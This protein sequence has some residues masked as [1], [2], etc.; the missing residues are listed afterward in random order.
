MGDEDHR[1]ERARL[2]DVVVLS[3]GRRVR[4]TFLTVLVL[5][6][7]L[8]EAFIPVGL[9]AV[10]AAVAG[11]SELGVLIAGGL[12]ALLVFVRV[13]SSVI[14]HRLSKLTEISLAIDLKR[15]IGDHVVAV[16]TTLLAD[17]E[18]GEA[19]ETAAADTSTVSEVVRV[20]STIVASVSTYLAVG[21]Y[22]VFQSWLLGV[23]VLVAA[24]VLAIGM[25][26][27][28]AGLSRRLKDHRRYA[29][30]V[31]TLSVDAAA[32]LLVLKGIGGE[33]AFLAG[34]V[35]ASS[36]MYEAGMR[37]AGVRALIEGAKVLVPT[38]V[39]LTVLGVGILQVQSGELSVGQLVVFYGL[40]LYLVAPVGA[41]VNAAQEVS[42][43]LVSL[44]RVRLL[45][46]QGTDAGRTYAEALETKLAP[47]RDERS[48]IVLMPGAMTTVISS[49]VES[50]RGLAERPAG[51]GAHPD[52]YAS[53]HGRGLGG[54]R[55]DD[56]RAAVLLA[57][58]D[59]YLFAGTLRECLASGVAD[60]A[61]LV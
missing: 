19:L 25:L 61:V 9:G 5:T 53:I 44:G 11:M 14:A 59:A 7:S 37:V 48:G 36:R 41:F 29:A 13:A 4:L 32:G 45:L 60:D 3:R 42:P 49:S 15:E 38:V 30:K 21:V 8:A 40:G 50:L 46:A 28:V 56:V 47:L 26:F 23:V 2:R 43:V 20:L 6:G 31:A 12:I 58:G 52:D 34:F 35:R 24:P 33:R 51:V 55:R 17:V 54:F 16:D 39:L 22:L 1:A 18:I 57:D 10:V 27:V